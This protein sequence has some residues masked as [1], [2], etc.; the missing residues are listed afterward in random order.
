[1]TLYK[2]VIT[3][4]TALFFTT[5]AFADVG[6]S[7]NEWFD[8]IGAFGNV[9]GPALVAGQT[10]TTISGGS[11]FMRT[12]RKTYNLVNVQLPYVRGGCGGIDAFAGSFSFINSEQFTA[13]LQNIANNALGLAFQMAVESISPQLARLIENMQAVAQAANNTNISS[14][15]AASS[16]LAMVPGISAGK[17]EAQEESEATGMLATLTGYTKD[18]ADTLEKLTKT[19]NGYGDSVKELEQANASMYD[20]LTSKNS[21]Y[22]ALKK[23][24]MDDET[25][26]LM[27]NIIGTIIF[28]SSS[29]PEV[30]EDGVA[31]GPEVK[32]FR[33]TF[34]DLI[35][36]PDASNTAVD[37]WT[38]TSSSSP[39]AKPEYGCMVMVEQPKSIPSF[40]Y[41]VKK[42]IRDG[43]DSMISRSALDLG[44]SNSLDR[45]LY[46]NSSVPLY[47]IIKNNSL[48]G[49]NSIADAG[50]AKLIAAELAYQYI[51]Q[52]I[53]EARKALANA[54]NA[55]H[56]Q[57]L[58]DSIM[59]QREMTDVVL[60][61]ARQG[62][63]TVYRETQANVAM[64]QQIKD[65]RDSV[66]KNMASP[67]GTSINLFRN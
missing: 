47:R 34:D 14:C 4:F 35:G 36:S 22:Y 16:L 10:H 39:S 58:A 52:S 3:A 19:I 48:T 13:M 64:F 27:M 60:E 18:A 51:T 6:S 63:A 17:Q 61:N 37:L 62:L 33:I 8:D 66:L 65:M 56:D 15:K 38:C 24:N 23:T 28:R 29:N 11:F 55:T 5:S 26:E 7:M 42:L 49:Y 32:E 54:N 12:P 43:E 20:K 45:A 67:I 53:G 41:R 25:I 30:T 1:M 46:T 2:R 21:T 57:N 31:P 9:S 44:A 59:W 50:V 40:L